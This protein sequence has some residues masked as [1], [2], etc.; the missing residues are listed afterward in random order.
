M[1]FAVESRCGITL[2]IFCIMYVELPTYL[3]N[4]VNLFMIYGVCNVYLNS[5]CK[6]FTN[7]FVSILLKE[8]LIIEFYHCFIIFFFSPSS[9]LSSVS[10]P[11]A[12]PPSLVIS[13]FSVD[14]RVTL[15]FQIWGS[16]S[17]LCILWSNLKNL[18]VISSLSL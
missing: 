7:Y 14:A 3:W 9:P 18:C 6:C 4:E 16:D 5:V 17:S 10:S 15:V 8:L 13:L 11:F 12:S 1:I 2:I